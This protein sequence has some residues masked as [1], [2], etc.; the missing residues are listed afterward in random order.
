MTTHLHLVP[1]LRMDGSIPLLPPY[2][3]MYFYLSC[4]RQ[5]SKRTNFSYLAEV[6]THFTPNVTGEWNEC[7]LR[8]RQVPGCPQAQDGTV[9][10]LSPSTSFPIH[11]SQIIT[12]LDAI[13]CQLLMNI[14][15]L[16]MPSAR[17]HRNSTVAVYVEHCCLQQ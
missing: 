13:Q 2:A 14:M 4:T 9:P 7:L 6:N 3:F 10:R 11:Y 17:G 5:V 8:I 12:P 16:V 1:W 15:W